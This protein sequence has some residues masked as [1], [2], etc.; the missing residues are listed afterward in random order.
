MPL[1]QPYI[2]AAAALTTAAASSSDYRALVYLFMNGGN[3][4]HNTVIPLGPQYSQYLQERGDLAI[5]LASVLPLKDISD[6]GLHPAFTGIK[7]IID[8][9]KGAIVCNVGQLVEPLDKVDY[10]AEWVPGP[11]KVPMSL[12]SHSDQQL[13]WHTLRPDTANEAAGWG[14]RFL[15]LADPAY[16]PNKLVPAGISAGGRTRTLDG[17]ES[18]QYQISSDINTPVEG[19]IGT[20]LNN[21]RN[22]GPVESTL[23]RNLADWKSHG[24]VN[25]L[26]Q[27]VAAA[28]TRALNFYSTYANAVGTS[29]MGVTFPSS[30]LGKQLQNIARL[31]RGRSKM[32]HRRDVFYVEIGGFD[33]HG[34][35][36]YAVTLATHNGLLS[37]IDLAVK[38]FYDEMVFQ[39][40]VDNVT[41]FT[42]SDFGRALK[43]NGSGSDHG[44]GGHHFVIG[45][46]VIGGK[47][48]ARNT[49]NGL[50]DNVFPTIT[51]NG[52]WDAGQGRLIPSISAV[53]YVGTMVKWMGIPD[54]T[55]NAVN[56]L[57]LV[58]PNLP[59]F[60]SRD[61]GFL[62]TSPTPDPAP[63]AAPVAPVTIP[64]AT[65][66]TLWKKAVG[67]G[68]TFTVAGTKLVRF[69]IDQSWIEKTVTG[70]VTCSNDFFGND[71]AYGVRKE[72]QIYGQ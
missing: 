9:G 64:G 51:F 10:G 59:A 67:E 60:A 22:G 66:P 38:A 35:E 11:G 20:G 6:A 70:Q 57:D 8:A 23:I 49:K 16:N 39:S 61:L 41:L 42:G 2:D 56:P 65:D 44:W 25:R 34:G 30:G 69:G 62:S 71:P 53:E 14:G 50:I 72:C 7:S 37:T 47:V 18:V 54:S 3:D 17:N 4:S 58:A 32:G 21:Y 63:V 33:L 13:Q 68:E 28:G 46:S 31:I 45:G 36:T 48:Y 5:P 29:K 24:S 43:P 26:E 27:A 12:F 19:F 40:L 52:P 55:S 15:D 1:T